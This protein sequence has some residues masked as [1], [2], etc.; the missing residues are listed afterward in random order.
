[1][2]VTL[3]LDKILKIFKYPVLFILFSYLIL[4]A[5]YNLGGADYLFHIKCGQVIVEEKQLPSS[6]IFSFTKNS[7]TWNDHE[8]L[9][10]VGLYYVYENFGLKGLFLLRIITFSLAFFLLTCIALKVDWVFSFPL[11]FY[12]L[13]ISFRRFTLRPDNLSF[14]FLILF[15]LP[16]VFK[17]RKLLFLMPLAQVLWVNIHGFF[18]LG[19]A[20]LAIYLLLVPGA[21]KSRDRKFY[22]SVKLNFLL[23]IFACFI[24]PH[25]G[26]ML[27]YPFIVIREI[28]SG[29]QKLFYQFIQELS[30]PLALARSNYVFLAYIAAG[31]VFLIFTPRKNWFYIGLFL[32][33][34]VFS[35]NSLRNMYFIVPVVMVVFIECYPRIKEAFSKLFIKEKGFLFLRISFLILAVAISFKTFGAIR[36]LPE[37]K[38][39]YLTEENKVVSGGLF[40]ARDPLEYPGKMIEFIG[41]NPLPEKMFNT[42]NIGAML[43]FNFYPQRQVFIDGRA[44]FYGQEFFSLYRKILEGDSQ[45]IDQA[46]GEYGLRGFMISY[47]KDKPPFLIRSLRDKNFSCVYLGSDG[48][49]FIDKDFIK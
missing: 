20:I 4:F 24:T 45:A 21:E 40:L 43:I 8:W 33:M 11:L 22:N 3:I 12:G 9:Y 14:L 1:M 36:Q 44:E 13:Q 47:F 48:I 15:L 49:I 18:F 16:F 23:C 39:D 5:C 19:P 25:P 41:K 7:K 35:L 2:Q 26:L 31:L 27:Q 6:D 10:Q 32:A 42:F 37:R 46:I 30:S 34:A 29:N 28:L 38:I 17:K